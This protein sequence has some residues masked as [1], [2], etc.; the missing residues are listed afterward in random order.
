[1]S[2]PPSKP[3]YPPSLKWLPPPLC[4]GLPKLPSLYPPEYWLGKY[5]SQFRAFPDNNK[6]RQDYHLVTFL[7]YV[8][9]PRFFIWGKNLFLILRKKNII[10]LSYVLDGCFYKEYTCN[11]FQVF[12]VLWCLVFLFDTIYFPWI[13]R[14][15]YIHDYQNWIYL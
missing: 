7:S 4:Y 13:Y 15:M 11:D 2:K 12:N 9:Y 6:Y 5:P 14:S 3:R 10:F 1:M 8:F